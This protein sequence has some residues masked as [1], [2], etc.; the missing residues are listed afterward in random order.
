M[1]EDENDS[2][3]GVFN[4]NSLKESVKSNTKRIVF[5]LFATNCISCRNEFQILRNRTADLN[6][7]GVQVYLV[8]VG[9]NDYEK[10]KKFAEQYAGKKFPL[11][12][13]RYGNIL[14]Y[15]GLDEVLPKMI[16][17]DSNLKPLKIL[18]GEAGNDF[19]E[20]LWK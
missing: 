3:N 4:L 7:N 16:V 19:P 10:V 2:Y 14:Q 5:S 15:F 9:E 1:S 20:I 18:I 13:D 12:F 11:Y 8:D 17:L 6:E